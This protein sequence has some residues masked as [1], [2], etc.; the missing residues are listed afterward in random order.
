MSKPFDVATKQLVEKDPIAWLRFLGLPGEEA[1]L[2]DADLSTVVAEADRIFRVRNPDYMAH[3]ELQATYKVDMGDRTFFY[4]AV[5]YYKYRIS[6]ESIVV[7]LR[8]E[9]DGPAMTGVVAYG[10]LIFRYRV[11]R[12]W[13]FTPEELLGAPLALLPLVP[14]TSVS[15]EDLPEIIQRMEARVEEGA[16]ES[17][18]EFWTAT[19]LLLGLRYNA[20]VAKQLLRGVMGMKES[21]TYQYMMEE[22]RAE[23]RIKGIQEGRQEGKQEGRQE[24]KQEGLQEGKTNEARRMLVLL[25]RKRLGELD[26]QTMVQLE[27]IFSS[28]ELERLALR[29]FEVESWQELLQ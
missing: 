18:N 24:G 1:E 23:G 25:G 4:N 29:L 26:A 11:V 2:V 3:L 22:G 19:W 17:R 10:S 7:L 13:L 20:E 15:P 6:V 8:K 9:A 21:S 27:A 14:L 5:T 16:P 12:L 28:E